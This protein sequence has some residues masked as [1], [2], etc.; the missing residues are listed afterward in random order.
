MLLWQANTLQQS[1]S[2]ASIMRSMHKPSHNDQPKKRKHKPAWL[3]FI[4]EELPLYSEEHSSSS[5]NKEACCLEAGRKFP[6]QPCG[7]CYSGKV[8]GTPACHNQTYQTAPHTGAP[9]SQPIQYIKQL[10]NMSPNITQWHKEMCKS[11]PASPKLWRTQWIIHA[12]GENLQ[13]MRGV[14]GTPKLKQWTV[15]KWSR[16]SKNKWRIKGRDAPVWWTLMKLARRNAAV[17]SHLVGCHSWMN[18]GLLWW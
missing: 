12:E 17:N 11:L 8:F 3:C 1:W 18:R 2:E 9:D 10:L 15:N 16:G 6:W 13:Q 5:R 14:K 7:L 4:S